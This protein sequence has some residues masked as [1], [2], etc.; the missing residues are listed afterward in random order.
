MDEVAY[1]RTSA[2]NNPAPC[3]FARALLVGCV[4]CELA[5]RHALAEREVIACSKPTARINCQTLAALF[6]ERA[7]FALRLPRPGTA[8]PHA[9]LLKLHCGGLLALQQV[10]A[11]PVADVHRMVTRCH[12]DGAGFG[13]L[14]W[15]ALV[16]AMLRW[17]LRRR[18]PALPRQTPAG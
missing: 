1:R 7:T 10:L 14:P 16:A 18:L 5:G 3:I 12:E 4:Q 13:D 17:Q 11:T 8:L 9:T 2:L 15:E 6:Y